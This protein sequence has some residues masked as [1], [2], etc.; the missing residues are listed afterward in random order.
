[1]WSRVVCSSA[2]SRCSRSS[3][4]RASVTSSMMPA[5][6]VRRAPSGGSSPRKRTST[7]RRP[8]SSR[9]KALAI[10]TSSPVSQVRATPSRSSVCACAGKAASAMAKEGASPEA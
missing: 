10:E 1:M 2:F 4:D 3:K 6:W 9:V 8:P 5:M 7:S